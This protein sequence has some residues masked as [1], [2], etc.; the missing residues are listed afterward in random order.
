MSL[1]CTGVHCKSAI[2]CIKYQAIRNDICAQRSNDA[3]G[4]NKT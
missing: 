3:K 2:H 1:M 4:R